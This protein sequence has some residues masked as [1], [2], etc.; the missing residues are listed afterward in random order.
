MLILASDWD[1]P[2]LQRD[3]EAA[4]GL[5][6]HRPQRKR[7]HLGASKK[8]PGG[9]TDIRLKHTNSSHKRLERKIFDKYVHLYTISQNCIGTFIGTSGVNLYNGV[10][11]CAMCRSTR[12]RVADALDSIDARRTENKFANNFNYAFR[13]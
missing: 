8:W 9:L 3:I 4:T 13:R 1:D 11:F 6:L 7:R 10:E 2:E 5:V 12:R